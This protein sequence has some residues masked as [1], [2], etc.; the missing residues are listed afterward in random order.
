MTQLTPCQELGY[1]V[2]DEFVVLVTDW[3]FTK[4]QIIKLYEDDGSNSPLF[5]DNNTDYN[6]ADG[7]EGAYLSLTKVKKVVK[8]KKVFD[9]KTNPWFI[10]V[11]NKEEFEAAISWAE[12][13]GLKW[14]K[15][16][17]EYNKSI[18]AIGTCLSFPEVQVIYYLLNN[19]NFC[20]GAREEIKITFKTIIES[21][22]YPEIETEQDKKI[23]ELQETIEIA[24]RQIEE[25]KGI[26]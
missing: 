15:I 7:K 17:R 6:N 8:E 20:Q 5:I 10:R 18:K 9:L 22:E 1:K 3:G 2:G 26:K 24:K 16:H 21:V 19:D 11:N 12:E 4:S 23:R 25:L 14:D 13:K